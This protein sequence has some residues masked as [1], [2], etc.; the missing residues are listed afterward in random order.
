MSTFGSFSPE[1]IVTM[2]IVPIIATAFSSVISKM[3]EKFINSLT[4]YLSFVFK[5]IFSREKKYNKI[6]VLLNCLTYSSNVDRYVDGLT[7]IGKAVVWFINEKKIKMKNTILMQDDKSFSL[8]FVPSYDKNDLSQNTRM[9][10]D[11][12]FS[13]T[14]FTGSSNIVIDDNVCFSVKQQVTTKTKDDTDIYEYLEIKSEKFSMHEL[15]EYINN[16][17]QLY[18]KYTKSEKPKMFIFKKSRKYTVVD[19]D[20][21]QNFNN[22]FFSNKHILLKDINK[23]NDIE[24]YAK[25]GMK[26]KLSY[27]FEGGPGTAKTSTAT[28]IAKMLNRNIVS[29]PV[30]RLKTN[31]DLEEIM[32]VREYCGIRYN[33]NEIVILFDEMDSLEGDVLLKNSDKTQKQEIHQIPNITINSG[34]SRTRSDSSDDDNYKNDSKDKENDKLN[35]GIFLSL[36]D[37][38]YDQDGMIIIGTVNNL[39][40]LD[41][42]FKRD[43]RLKIINFENA[44]RNEIREMIEYYYDVKLTQEQIDSICDDKTVN[45]LTIK[46]LC[47]DYIDNMHNIDILIKQINNLFIK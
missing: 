13:D 5:K 27:L 4:Y 39:A 8:F 28:A 26:R 37:G 7:P 31:S 43:G 10:H 29:V 18:E 44:G 30:S 12:Q 23:F 33:A 42:A 38:N 36:L 19:I 35:V 14:T 32:Y 2:T 21:S 20:N 3:V 40:K 34:R 46:K 15:S 24:F 1:Q 9:I 6:D 16:I 25:H 47:V 41:D 11:T 45:T 17:Q 22:L